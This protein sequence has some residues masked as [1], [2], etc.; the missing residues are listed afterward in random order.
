[1]TLP[2]YHLKINTAYAE[3]VIL[4]KEFVDKQFNTD[5]NLKTNLFKA[6]IGQGG[7]LQVA[8]NHFIL[9]T[10]QPQPISMSDVLAAFQN[11]GSSNSVSSHKNNEEASIKTGSL[12]YVY[13]TEFWSY[14]K[15]DLGTF[16]SYPE[17]YH[18]SKSEFLDFL[19]QNLQKEQGSALESQKQT[20]IFVSETTS[21][22]QEQF[23]WF[24]SK[25]QKTETSALGS[26]S[27]VLEPILQKAVPFIEQTY[28]AKNFHWLKSLIH[29][30]ENNKA[31]YIYGF[32]SQSKDGLASQGYLGC[33][34]ETLF[35]ITKDF[36]LK[37]MALAGTWVSDS[38]IQSVQHV[39]LKTLKEHQ[40][41]VQDIEQQLKKYF[42]NIQREP[43]T[44]QNYKKLS[45]LKT[46][47]KVSLLPQTISLAENFLKAIQLLHPTAALGVYP[48]ELSWA[49]EFSNLALQNKRGHFGAPLGYLS[50]GEG[51]AFVTIRQFSWRALN[52][53][54]NFEA[55]AQAKVDKCGSE[56]R[57]AAQNFEAELV[58]KAG[59]GLT[60]ESFYEAELT[61]VRE[62]IKSVQQIFNVE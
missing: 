15:S 57:F 24:T 43:T 8:E 36:E 10:G 2:N 12:S 31:H 46:P 42:T 45:H 59:C 35:E 52:V 4:I 32:W 1:M 44:V 60:K 5:Q 50:A 6:F 20:L 56:N 13:Q 27:E 14:L 39:D 18:L 28:N 9:F 38:Q 55:E 58:F 29:A 22:F 37:T 62:K 51:K 3:F 7:V 11:Q 61:E 34:P 21:A 41:V 17:C 26:N 54:Q 30:V 25:V 48:R 19:T 53:V 47:I 40:L 49:H 23:D 16:V 33:T